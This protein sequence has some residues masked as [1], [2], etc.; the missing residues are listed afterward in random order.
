MYFK[1]SK[2]QCE[3]IGRLGKDVETKV[4]ESGSKVSRLSI[5]TTLCTKP[6]D[7]EANEKNIWI[8]LEV[9]GDHP[10]LPYLKK[11]KQVSV[12]AYYDTSKTGEGDDAKFYHVFKITNILLL[13]DSIKHDEE[14]AAE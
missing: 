1:A 13:G 2:N 5:N 10:A 3:F 9:W 12:S 14:L 6:K 8:P 4:L 11:G 7:K